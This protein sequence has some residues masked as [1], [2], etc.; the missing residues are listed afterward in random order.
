MSIQYQLIYEALADTERRKFRNFPVRRAFPW[1]FAEGE[2]IS[3]C[4]GIQDLF[5]AFRQASQP[6]SLSAFVFEVP[7][8]TVI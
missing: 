1:E 4:G 5:P 6:Q 8:A 7:G 3:P 2:S